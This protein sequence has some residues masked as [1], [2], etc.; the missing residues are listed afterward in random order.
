[1]F[2]GENGFNYR[3]KSTSTL[4]VANVRLYRTSIMKTSADVSWA[5]PDTRLCVDQTEGVFLISVFLF[6]RKGIRTCTRGHPVFATHE[7]LPQWRSSQ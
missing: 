7:K 6:V 5:L 2:Q 4:G 1:M 3:R